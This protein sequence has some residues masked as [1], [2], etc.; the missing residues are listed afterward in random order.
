MKYDRNIINETDLWTWITHSK[1]KINFLVSTRNV[2]NSRVW[3]LSVFY[4][5]INRFLTYENDRHNK[6][7]N[8]QYY[9]HHQEDTSMT[10]SAM[11][12][13]MLSFWGTDALLSFM[14]ATNKYPHITRTRLRSKLW[15]HLRVSWCRSH[16]RCINVCLIM[17]TRNQPQP[18]TCCQEK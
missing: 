12:T 17:V 2:P 5:T 15:W 13:P 9:R 1:D 18:G 14:D 8:S 16:D 7:F 6:Y 4:N 3:D 10:C 11:L